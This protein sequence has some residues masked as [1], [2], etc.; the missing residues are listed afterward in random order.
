[1]SSSLEGIKLLNG[2]IH[3]FRSLVSCGWPLFVIVMYLSCFMLVYSIYCIVV[4]SLLLS[5][6]I[7][8]PCTCY[9][10]SAAPALISLEAICEWESNVISYTSNFQ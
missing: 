5:L 6:S 4:S 2:V 1:M 9:M 7:D 10:S 3:L 8:K